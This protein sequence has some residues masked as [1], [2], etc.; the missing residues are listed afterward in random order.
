MNHISIY[1]DDYPTKDGTCIRDYLHVT[2]LADAHMLAMNKL[3]SGG[4][5]DVYNLGSGSGFSVLEMI[6]VAR[7]VTNHPIP[8]IDR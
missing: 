5:S 2:D 4:D 7:K 1:G 8:A 3:R 6:E